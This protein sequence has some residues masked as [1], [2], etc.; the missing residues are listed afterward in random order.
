MEVVISSTYFFCC[1]LDSLSLSMDKGAE[2]CVPSTFNRKM[3]VMAA[4]SS[5]CLSAVQSLSL[6]SLNKDSDCSPSE[7]DPRVVT[8]LGETLQNVD[9]WVSWENLNFD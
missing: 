5:F 2:W 1:C 3:G 8:E 7:S 4:F 6:H 9:D